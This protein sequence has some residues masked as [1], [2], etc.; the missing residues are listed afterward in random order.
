VVYFRGQRAGLPGWLDLIACCAVLQW[1][2]LL[3]TVNLLPFR[4]WV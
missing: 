1:T 4:L 2:V 3:Y